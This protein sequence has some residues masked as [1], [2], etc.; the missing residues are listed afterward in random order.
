MGKRRV[1]IK[2]ETVFISV[3]GT[4]AELKRTTLF[5]LCNHWVIRILHKDHIFMYYLYD[6]KYIKCQV[7]RNLVIIGIKK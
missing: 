5:S 4:Q 2:L 3:P 1:N 7:Q 6:E